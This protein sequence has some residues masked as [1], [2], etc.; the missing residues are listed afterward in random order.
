M[1]LCHAEAILLLIT[2]DIYTS[3]YTITI[4]KLLV[5]IT[6]VRCPFFQS[7]D[8]LF[9]FCHLLFT[10]GA[11]GFDCFVYNNATGRLIY[12]TENVCWTC[13][14]PPKKCNPEFFLKANVCGFLIEYLKGRGEMVSNLFSVNQKYSGRFFNIR[15]RMRI[16][17]FIYFPNTVMADNFGECSIILPACW[18]K[19]VAFKCLLM[20]A[21]LLAFFF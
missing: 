8:I 10:F 11:G 17:H 15:G 14:A 9:R 7:Y 19:K 3:S 21:C 13:R 20:M 16:Y 2:P 4:Y 18:M 6:C 1:L 12:L 5:T